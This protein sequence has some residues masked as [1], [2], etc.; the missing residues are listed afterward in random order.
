MKRHAPATERNRDAIAGVLAE[1]LPEIGL[2]FEVASGSGEHAVHFARSFPKLNWHPSDPDPEAVASIAAWRND[3]GLPNLGK[4]FAFATTDADSPLDRADAIFCAN[5]IHISAWA[6]SI[7]L[8]HHAARLLG[9]GA[10]LVLYGPF[11]EDDVPTAP[12]NLDFDASLS[13]RNPAWGIRALNDVDALAREH[14]FA[15]TAR[16]AMPANNLILVFRRA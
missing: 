11:I 2:V 8:F 7:G 5:M 1:E 16:Y 4:P 3:A 6:S 12:S 10:P 13:L 14:G 15:R 9:K